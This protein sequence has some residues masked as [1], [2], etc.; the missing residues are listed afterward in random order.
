MTKIRAEKV[1]RVVAKIPPLEVIG[2]Q[3]GELLIVGWGST[4][5][6]IHTAINEL[7]EDGE[8]K[9]GF[10]QFNYI[11]PL[12]ANTAEIFAKFSKILVCELN[13]GQFVN[14]LR[15]RMPEF[16]YGQY[17]KIQGQPFFASEIK[18]QII[19]TLTE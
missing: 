8:T 17:N 18:A 3:S 12:P 10:A 13:N 15:G 14:Y 7:I 9:V 1:Q 6:A 2:A 19:N 4:G 5:G 11:N 16:T